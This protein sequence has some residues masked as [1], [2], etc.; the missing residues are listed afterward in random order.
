MIVHLQDA[1]FH[2]R[3]GIRS[4]NRA[5]DAAPTKHFAEAL[6]RLSQRVGKAIADTREAEDIAR[7]DPVA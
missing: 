5:A 2:L 6:D 1:V 7:K 4:L 3:H